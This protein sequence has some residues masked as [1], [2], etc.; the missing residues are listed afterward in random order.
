MDKQIKQTANMI[1]NSDL[2]EEVITTL[3]GEMFREGYKQGSREL[4]FDAKDKDLV[5]VV[6]MLSELDY[7]KK[8]A[9]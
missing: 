7:F 1:V 6:A 2:S 4:T 5:K 9:N 8:Q 3:L